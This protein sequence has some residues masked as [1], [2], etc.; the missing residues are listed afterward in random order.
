MHREGVR[1]KVTAFERV[2][3]QAAHNGINHFCLKRSDKILYKCTRPFVQ[4]TEIRV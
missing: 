2:L 4:E 3:S 1:L